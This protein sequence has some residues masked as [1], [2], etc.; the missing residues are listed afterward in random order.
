MQ[1]NRERARPFPVERLRARPEPR[2]AYRPGV[3]PETRLP[4][5]SAL[6]AARRDGLQ[7]WAFKLGIGSDRLTVPRRLFET[8]GMIRSRTSG[9]FSHGTSSRTFV[10]LFA[11]APAR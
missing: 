5:S 9:R 8:Y 4:H 6:P 3:G 1:A 10:P 7:G 11:S 2:Q